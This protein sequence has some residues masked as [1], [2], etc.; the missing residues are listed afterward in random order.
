MVG[1]H[2]VVPWANLPIIPKNAERFQPIFF[3]CST[4]MILIRQHVHPKN[5][6]PSLE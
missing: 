1:A 3:K 2:F 4:S 6:D 5:P